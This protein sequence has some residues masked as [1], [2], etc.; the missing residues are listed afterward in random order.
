[1]IEKRKFSNTLI[2]RSARLLKSNDRK[3]IF[4][5]LM[6][7]L[8][9]SG[10]DLIGVAFTGVLTSILVN[11]VQSKE[12][13]DRTNF[14]LQILSLDDKSLNIQI[15]VLGFSACI[16]FIA[17]TIFSMLFLKR[18]NL[19]IARR[20][21]EISSNLISK[22]LSQPLD[23]LNNKSIQ[24]MIYMVTWGV[25]NIT[26]GV[27][28]KVIEILSDL[29]LLIIMFAGLLVIDIYTAAI[30]FFIFFLFSSLLYVLI[31]VRV[32]DL[33]RKTA[34]IEIVSNQKVSEVI[35]SYREIF[36]SNRR[37]YYSNRIGK[38][39]FS[40]AELS[41]ELNFLPSISKYM[42]EI[43]VIF[44]VVIISVIQF[45]INDAA[46][47]SAVTAIFLAS[48][49][50]IAPSILRLQNSFVGI[51]T[52]MGNAE[53]TLYF[54]ESLNDVESEYSVVDTMN[55]NHE[56]FD[57]SIE[58]VNL[59]KKYSSSEVE[60]IADVNLSIN[61]GQI[62]A[63]VGPSGG[64]K[65][66]LIDL[67]LGILN[68]D[69]GIIS[70]SGLLP[71]AAIRKWPG[72]ISYVPQNIAIMDGSIRHNITLGYDEYDVPDSLIWKSLELADLAEFVRNLPGQLNF[73][74]GDRGSKLSGGQRQR[75]GIARALISNP[76][77]LILDEATS[78]LD[79][80]TE[81]NITQAIQSLRGSTTVVIAA[82]RLSTIR[83][84]DVVIYIESGK[85]VAMGT[86]QYVRDN[87]KDFNVQ[88][89]IMGL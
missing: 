80:E 88:A 62:V 20:S 18:S 85:I 39:R 61:K 57:P 4:I 28:V 46:K 17:K 27:I 58:I 31:R 67:M 70:I 49:T 36:V 81:S 41:A 87:V 16:F 50:R 34:N 6:I 68:P 35:Q 37:G 40:L 45:S 1:M 75:L 11:S 51:R 25:N 44:S 29:I 15:F 52:A 65:T 79:G 33:S 64:G 60:A 69:R 26:M 14:V 78:S 77:L 53:P 82:H 55:I 19:F 86:F 9:L 74:V 3:K 21:A 63:L 89:N 84:A 38:L 23:R 76:R 8:I 54:I 7:Q 83:N 43:L 5:V 72:A 71:T 30:T 10:L 22:I 42:I 13:G 59:A 24:E 32:L 2:Y 47:A 66:T 12:I 48:S 73:K 56:E